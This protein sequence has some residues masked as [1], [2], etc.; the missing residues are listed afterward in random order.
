MPVPTFRDV[1]Y[2]NATNETLKYSNP[3]FS[4]GY[5][6]KKPL[7]I[8]IEFSGLLPGHEYEAY[9]YSMNMNEIFS[10]NAS[11]LYFRTKGM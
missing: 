7:E 9:F 8:T 5:V 4:V 1:R 11:K 3:I 10:Q 6:R 2:M